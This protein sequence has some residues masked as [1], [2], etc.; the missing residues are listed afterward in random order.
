[1]SAWLRPST[2][3]ILTSLFVAAAVLRDPAVSKA[4]IER[5]MTMMIAAGIA[6]ELAVW[7]RLWGQ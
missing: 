3:V 1:M 4:F 6:I 5:K 7:M 2:F